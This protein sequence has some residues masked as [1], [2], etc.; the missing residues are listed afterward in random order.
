MRG[1]VGSAR[2][3]LTLCTDQIVL[4][5]QPSHKIVNFLYSKLVVNNK[6]TIFVGELTFLN[7]F[8]DTLCQ[9]IAHC[10]VVLALV[11]VAVYTWWATYCVEVLVLYVLRCVRTASISCQWCGFSPPHVPAVLPTAGSKYSSS[12]S[13]LSYRS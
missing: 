5:S 9:M 4:V 10:W 8:I 2:A 13:L 1:G 12:S 3:H 7:H 11:W 6:S